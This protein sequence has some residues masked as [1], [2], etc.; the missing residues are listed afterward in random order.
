L[1]TTSERADERSVTK[2]EIFGWCMYD[3]ADSAFTTVIVTTLYALYFRKIVAGN[4]ENADFLWGLAASISEIV[5]AIL[6]PILGAIADFSGSRKKFLAVCAA[7]IVFFTASL[8][9]VGPGMVVVGLVLYIVANIGFSGGG[10]FI[11]SF[12]P[13]I[14]NESNA[15]RISGTKWALGYAS[16]LVAL[17]ACL[18]LSK[19][20]VDDPTPEQLGYARLIPVVV[21]AYY[22]VAVIPTLLFLR[23]RSVPQPLPPGDNYV[24]VGFR[25]L[26][27]TLRH[28]GRYRELVKLLV[29]FLIYND[30]IVTVIYFAAIYAEVTIGFAPNEIV[31]MFIVLNVIAV[32]G[33]LSFG[34]LADRIGQKRVIIISLC[35]WIA[36]VVL[37][38]FAYSKASFWVVAALA[39]IGIGSSQ[40]VSRSLVAL[41]TPKENAAEFFGFLGIAGKALAFLGPLVFGTIS[42]MTGSQRPAILSI[43][44]FFVIGIILIARVDEARGKAASRIPIGP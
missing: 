9:F 10:V 18:P 22:A 31:M 26:R 44:I 28:L 21:A 34:L 20:I 43:G 25:Q 42:T 2:L 37:A 4:A 5:V 3:V 40:S 6:A 29:A 23:E 16:G 41:F 39:G 35:I 1:T 24:T 36:A 13:G 30:G 8:Y 33:A 11:D 32:A 15:G 27:H 17:A 38:Y 19:Y 12:L 14:S 7:T